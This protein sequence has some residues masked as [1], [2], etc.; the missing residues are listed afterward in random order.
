MEILINYSYSLGNRLTKRKSA[1]FFFVFAVKRDGTESL[2]PF[3]LSPNTVGW[4]V[5]RL[6]SSLSQSNP[7]VLSPSLIRDLINFPISP[8]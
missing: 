6:F 1:I 7:C 2:H 5:C 4:G 8:E 3:Q